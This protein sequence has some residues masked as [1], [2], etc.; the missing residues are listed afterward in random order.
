MRRDGR[1][2][3]Y[4][5]TVTH[6]LCSTT[7]TSLLPYSLSDTSDGVKVLTSNP[8]GSLRTLVSMLVGDTDGRSDVQIAAGV[9]HNVDRGYQGGIEA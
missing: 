7:R 3:V 4:A 8:G 9:S 1:L 5:L 6:W 2:H